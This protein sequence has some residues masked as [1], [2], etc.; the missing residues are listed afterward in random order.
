VKAQLHVAD[1]MDGLRAQMPPGRKLMHVLL[2][3]PC[4]HCGHKLTM[5]GNWFSVIG[6]YPC[7]LRR[8]N[9]RMTYEVKL[10]LFDSHAHLGLP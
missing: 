4:A 8:K 5:R 10:A 7:A 3:H 2:S 9:V 1:R 6:S